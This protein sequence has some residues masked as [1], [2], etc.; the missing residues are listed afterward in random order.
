MSRKIKVLLLSLIIGIIIISP[1]FQF[2]KSVTVMSISSAVQRKNSLLKEEG[3]KIKIPGGL[4]TT[5]KDWYPFVMTFN[6][7]KGFSNYIGKD[8]QLSILYNFGAFDFINGASTFYDSSSKYYN[9]FYGA[10][11]IKG[12]NFSFGYNIDQTP[13][14]DEMALVAKYDMTELVLNSLR[15]FNP[16]FFLKLEE[17]RSMDS[18]IGYEN[19]EVIDATVITNAPMHKKKSNLQ[20]YIQYGSPPKKLY[21]GKDFPLV[22][23][24]GRFYAR[25][26]KENGCSIFFYI[27]ATDINTIEEWEK[28][29][30][31]NTKLSVE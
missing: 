21:K 17:G 4:S 27:F 18:L 19:W 1:F 30:L 3:I 14:Y 25:Y 11:V 12:Q 10:Y 26:F 9:A 13:N 16:T 5:K 6:S 31:P 2:L 15:C 7:S 29:I 24:K 8:V 23:M 20:S 28:D 22:E